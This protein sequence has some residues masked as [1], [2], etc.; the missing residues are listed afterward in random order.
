MDKKKEVFLLALA[1]MEAYRLCHSD[2]SDY[3]IRVCEAILARALGY[4]SRTAW[5]ADIQQDGLFDYANDALQQQYKT[6]MERI[7]KEVN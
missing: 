4:K 7:E 6:L 3:D 5:T 1:T 2:R